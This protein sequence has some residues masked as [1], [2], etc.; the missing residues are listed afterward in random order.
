MKVDKIVQR[1]EDEVKRS[2]LKF[3][4]IEYLEATR[5]LALNWSTEKCRDSRLR[6]VLPVRRGKRGTKPGKC[7]AGPRGAERGG[8][9]TVGIPH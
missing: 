3:S 9:R 5:Y 7:G 4:N 8:P 6:R 1:I 2:D